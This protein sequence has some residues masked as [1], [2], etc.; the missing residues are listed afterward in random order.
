MAEGSNEFLDISSMRAPARPDPPPPGKPEDTSGDEANPEEEVQEGAVGDSEESET[1]ESDEAADGELDASDDDEDAESGTDESD[2]LDID[3]ETETDP[4]KLRAYAKA[5]AELADKK[6]QERRRWQRSYDQA[7]ND[8][9]QVLSRGRGSPTATEDG[10]PTASAIDQVLNHLA[11]NPDE[12]VDRKELRT[13]LEGLRD[14]QQSETQRREIERLQHQV[15]ETLGAKD[16][17]TEVSEFF[18]EQGLAKTPDAKLL[19]PLGNY[20]YGLSQRLTE[21]NKELE[22]ELEKARKAARKAGKSGQAK[23]MPPVAGGTAKRQPKDKPPEDP[24]MLRIY[25]RRK[26]RLGMT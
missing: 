21:K 6:E 4:A 9:E 7:E 2:P 12:Y 3:P 11:E 22:A 25:N 14:G 13:V 20:Y 16:N 26:Q 17:L 18:R 1:T 10:K 19:N 23:K 8:L 24:F 15:N 5:Q